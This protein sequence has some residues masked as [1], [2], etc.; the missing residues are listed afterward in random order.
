MI[1]TVKFLGII[2]LIAIIGLSTVVCGGNTDANVNNNDNNSS[3]PVITSPIF[4]TIEEMRTWLSNQPANGSYIVRLNID[5]I[6]DFTNLRMVLINANNKYVNLDLSDSLIT[7]IPENAFSSCTTLTGITI[8]NTVDSIGYNSFSGCTRFT[9]INVG[10]ASILYSSQDGVLYN[11]NKTTLILYPQG[12]IGAFTIPDNVISIDN[13]AF[14]E[15][16]RLESL[17]IGKSVTSIGIFNFYG[18]IGLT[19]IN[20]DTSNTNYSSQEGVMY[21]KNKTILI[22]YP[23]GKTGVFNILNNITDIEIF[24]F[25][26]C[27]C[28]TSVTIPDSV[29]SIDRETFRDC[30]NLTSVTIGNGVTSIENGTFGSCT[31]LIRVTFTTGSNIPDASFEDYAFPGD[32]KIAYATGKDGTYTREVNGSIWT[33]QP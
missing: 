22:R 4:N 10:S 15:C 9:A 23:P 17:T 28:I 24:A 18:C 30:T 5:N 12:R 31:N 33:K 2:V 25:F 19:S 27:T 29:I 32:L 11:K 6:A 3:V 1:K 8:P 13:N 16:V 7:S 14:R 21:N 20:V 26:Y